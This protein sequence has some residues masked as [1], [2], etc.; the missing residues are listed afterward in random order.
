MADKLLRGGSEHIGHNQPKGGPNHGKWG[1]PE[2]EYNEQVSDRRMSMALL[3]SGGAGIR[4]NTLL[5]LHTD[6]NRLGNTL[7]STATKIESIQIIK[8][9]STELMSYEPYI[10]N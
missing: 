7:Y 3:Q 2:H 9:H 4:V 5:T 6:K 1:E 8:G 10:L